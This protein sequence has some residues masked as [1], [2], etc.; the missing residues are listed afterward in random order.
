M[1]AF[2]LSFFVF[3]CLASAEAEELICRYCAEA[4]Q[5]MPLGVELDGKY[6]Y[7]P[8]RQ[9]DVLH[10]KLDVTP[11]FSRR[12]VRGTTSIT[13][14]PISRPVELLRLDAKDIQVKDVR[15]DEVGVADFVSTRNELK[16]LL[17]KP[18]SPGTKVTVHIDYHAQ[19]TA[20]LYFRTPEM[21]YPE[22]DTH[23]WT[24]GE[25]HEARHWFP[26]FD[27][28][29]ERSSTE[30]ICHVPPEHDRSQ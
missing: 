12:T 8:D 10:I 20:G 28:P 2:L 23:I 18:V 26:C 4:H 9:V 11:D 29:N 1:R 15:C 22:S 13:A 25:T 19:P 5:E 17:A 24:Q 16:I 3:T 7:A 14:T 21:G 6:Q 27:Y 30:I